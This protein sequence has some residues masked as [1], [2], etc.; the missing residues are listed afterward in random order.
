MRPGLLCCPTLP[1]VADGDALAHGGVAKV[2]QVG[3]HELRE[4]ILQVVRVWRQAGRQT[5]RD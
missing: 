5:G 3:L 1:V 4:E 2:E